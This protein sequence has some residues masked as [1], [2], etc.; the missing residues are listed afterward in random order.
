[1]L[2]AWS[3]FICI[4]GSYSIMHSL[5]LVTHICS[6]F[7]ARLYTSCCNCNEIDGFRSVP[8][9]TIR[10]YTSDRDYKH[11]RKTYNVNNRVASYGM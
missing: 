9:L 2:L 3:V 1:M 11:T 6:H 4:V 7:S 8:D 5:S 10:I